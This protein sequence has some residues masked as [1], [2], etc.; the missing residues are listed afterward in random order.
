VQK[1]LEKRRRV[2]I[3]RHIRNMNKLININKKTN[4]K[5]NTDIIVKYTFG[6]IATGLFIA[7]ICAFGVIIVNGIISLI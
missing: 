1:C 6:T 3:F 4:N 7:N 2:R 5:M